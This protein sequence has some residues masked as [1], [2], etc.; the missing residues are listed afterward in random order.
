MK[1]IRKV[2]TMLL[3]VC[4]MIPCFS[5]VS[6]AASGTLQFTDPTTKVG[7]TVT[8]EAKMRTGGGAIGDGNVT[9]TYDPAALEFISGEHATGSGGVVQLSSTGDGAVTELTYS[10]QFKVLKEGESTL[11]VSE[12]TAYLYSNENLEVT[13]GSSKVTA[14]P[15][16]VTPPAPVEGQTPVTTNGTGTPVDV[17][18]TTYTLA[19]D[20]SEALIP[21]GFIK[22]TMPYEGKECQVLLQETSGMY[23]IYLQAQDGTKSFFLYNKENGKFSPFEEIDITQEGYIALLQDDVK[24]KLPDYYEKTTMSMEGNSTQYPAWQNTKNPE[25][26]VVYALSSTGKKSFYQYDTVDK[27]YQRFVAPEVIQQD[28]STGTFGKLID[29]AKENMGKVLMVA[30]IVF[31]LMLLAMII[32]AV[33]LRHRNLE[34]DDLY[35]EYNI[36]QEDSYSVPEP[37]QKPQKQKAKSV[38]KKITDEDD[39][40][41]IIEEDF[42]ETNEDFLE[43]FEEPEDFEEDFEEEP[44]KGNKKKPKSHTDEDG[45]FEFN[46]IDLDD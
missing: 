2:A 39:D 9:V 36:D 33:K 45:D 38:L 44:V 13:L 17:N 10:M 15:G 6:H 37:K 43:D 27:T 46:F 23:L 34:L 14:A 11:S 41:E 1:R 26:Y 8:V 7:E 40:F 22:T 32:I 42:A 25:F 19:E 31:L 4:F 35:D 24:A 30:W 21:V 29:L 16:D 28:K 12:C 3:A 20:F 18:G 5:L